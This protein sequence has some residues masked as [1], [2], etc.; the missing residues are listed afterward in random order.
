MVGQVR[1]NGAA[2]FL[3]WRDVGTLPPVHLGS[4]KEDCV[5]CSGMTIFRDYFRVFV[6][7]PHCLWITLDYFHSVGVVLTVWRFCVS[8]LR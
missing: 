2:A 1:C 7:V 3:Q 5:F 4:L 8:F 6:I